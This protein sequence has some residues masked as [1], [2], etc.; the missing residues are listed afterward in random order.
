MRE[1]LNR[2]KKGH[3]L[4]IMCEDD[5]IMIHLTSDIVLKEDT[6]GATGIRL[7]YSMHFSAPCAWG[8]HN[9]QWLQDKNSMFYING[10]I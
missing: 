10:G 6:I 9:W 7:H 4:F 3:T 2:I 5:S 8:L 1:D